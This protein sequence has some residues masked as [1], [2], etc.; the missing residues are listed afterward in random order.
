MLLT[1]TQ[2]SKRFRFEKTSITEILKEHNVPRYPRGYFED[3]AVPI[4]RKAKRKRI[5]ISP[6]RRYF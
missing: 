2:L 5:M 6:T 4:L 3:E 1:I